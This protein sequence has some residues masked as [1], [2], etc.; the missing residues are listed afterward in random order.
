MSDP[1]I[2]IGR[3][4]RGGSLSED[5]AALFDCERAPAGDLRA[6]MASSGVPLV[7]VTPALQAALREGIAPCKMTTDGHPA[8]AGY[9]RVA[10]LVYDATQ[11]GDM[12]LPRHCR[13][14]LVITT[15]FANSAEPGG[16]T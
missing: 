15:A 5:Y 1:R 12:E 14:A 10:R 11:R 9:D 4:S 3:K 16:S 13:D 8:A 2:V 6:A 7:D